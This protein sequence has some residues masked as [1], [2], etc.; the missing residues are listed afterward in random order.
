VSRDRKE[1]YRRINERVLIM[2]QQGW[3]D[4]VR[5]LMG[6]DWQDY[7][8][9]KKIIGYNEIITY[10]QGSQTDADYQKMVAEI[11]QRCR[12]YAKRQ[13]TFWRML[14]KQLEAAMH[15]DNQQKY[16]VDT[17]MLD[18]TLSSPDLYIKQLSDIL[19]K[20]IQ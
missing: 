11:Q 8:M 10:L 3:I 13:Y 20:R 1:L 17:A 9:R 14:K 15:A 4:E 12:N 6:T 16:T 18:L 19:K 7:L 2:I 5:A